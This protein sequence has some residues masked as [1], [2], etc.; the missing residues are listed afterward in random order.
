VA[1]VGTDGTAVIAAAE[2]LGVPEQGRTPFLRRMGLVQL[3]E[4]GDGALQRAP[5]GAARLFA[6]AAR[7][8]AEP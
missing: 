6:D 3:N 7:A 8:L 1:T 4:T 2:P 5:I